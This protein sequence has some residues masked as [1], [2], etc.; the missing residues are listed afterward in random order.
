MKLILIFWAVLLHGCT[1]GAG[2]NGMH[3]G[4]VTDVSQSGWFCK[5]WEG[6]LISA[7]GAAAI[8][9]RFTIEGAETL[10]ALRDAQMNGHEINVHYISPRIAGICRTS[11]SN[12]VVSAEPY[13]G[14]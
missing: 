12:I 11:Y 10:Q 6:E 13:T 3:R 7:K 5:T 9:Y 1:M 4:V 8:R 14:L 2:E